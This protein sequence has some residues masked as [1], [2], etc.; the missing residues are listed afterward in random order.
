MPTEP[1][2]VELTYPGQGGDALRALLVA[3]AGDSVEAEELPGIVL[4]HEVFGVDLHLTEIAARFAREGYRV[5]VPDLYSR[6]GLPGPASTPEDPAPAWEL[7]TIRATVAGLS[8]RR[9]LADLD[10]G[11]AFLG[12]RG[13]VDARSIAI[14]G[15]CMGGT[16][17]FLSGCTSTRFAAVVDFYGRPLYGELSAEKPTQPLEL[18]LNLDRPLLAIFGDADDSIPPEHVEYLR[19]ALEDAHK[20]FELMVYPG[21][22]HS[23]FNHRRARH[24]EASAMDA[25]QRTLAF[26][27]ERL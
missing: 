11:A 24:H 7:E 19:R 22:G 18:L 5:L 9:A 17:A 3:P 26:L 25:W 4:V 2:T 16:L 15:F 14:V 10:A 6:E 21:A 13:D 27:E 20:D 1:V 23:F 12:A 8:D